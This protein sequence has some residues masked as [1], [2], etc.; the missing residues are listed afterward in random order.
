MS[1]RTGLWVGFVLVHAIVALAG[2]LLP[3]QPMGDTYLVYEPWAASIVAGGPIMGIDQSWVYPQLALLPLVLAYPLATL[4]GYSASWAVL[5]TL[6]NGAVFAILIGKATSRGR[7]S[8]GRFW[9]AAILLLGPV[10]MYRLDAITVPLAVLGCLWLVGRPLIAGILL[11]AATWIKVWPAALLAAGFAAVR[12]RLTLLGGAGLATGVIVG[13]VL[14]A[15]GGAHVLGFLQAQGSRGLQVEAPVSAPFLWAALLGSPEHA[16]AY[17]QE[18]L[19]FEVAG[20]GVAEVAAVMNA[21]LVGAAVVIGVLGLVAVS[22]GAGFARLFPALALTLVLVLVVF[23]KVGSPQFQCWLLA[24]VILGLV[25]DRRRWRGP[26][27][28]VLLLCVLTQLVYPVLYA[29]ILVPAPLAVTL[30][31]IRNLGSV[32]LLL[33]MA[34]R[35]ARLAVAARTPALAVGPVA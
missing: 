16:V 1:R 12:E 32:I 21:L 11:A 33:W 27:A 4:V 22:R 26:A 25:V 17:N 29:G 10:G 24:P 7:V 35:V 34:T 9:L 23:N 6:L 3:N 14:V 28:V 5:V 8:A 30:L 19:T 13:V 2:F 18:I 31:T 20:T 15:G